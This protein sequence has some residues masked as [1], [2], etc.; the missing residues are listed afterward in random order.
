MGMQFKTFVHKTVDNV[1]QFFRALITSKDHPVTRLPVPVDAMV[2]TDVEQSASSDVELLNVINS[3]LYV[4]NQPDEASVLEPEAITY[5]TQADDDKITYPT[6]VM[7]EAVA[8]NKEEPTNVNTDLEQTE[9]LNTNLAAD[10]QIKPR[11]N[12]TADGEQFTITAL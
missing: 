3:E 12:L 11:A 9:L 1:R 8:Q 6:A 7:Q 5:P 4:D 2:S 10:S